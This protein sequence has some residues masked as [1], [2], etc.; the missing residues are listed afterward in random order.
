[1]DSSFA[2]PHMYSDE[3]DISLITCG[4]ATLQV[5]TPPHEQQMRAGKHV[6]TRRGSLVGRRAADTAIINS[7]DK[8]IVKN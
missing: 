5:V 6:I 4:P 2:E 1:M 3:M 8:S 7:G